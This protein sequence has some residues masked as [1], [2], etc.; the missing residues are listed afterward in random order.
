MIIIRKNWSASRHDYK[1]ITEVLRDTNTYIKIKK[2]PMRNIITSL[3]NLLIRWKDSK[4]ISMSIYKQLLSSDGIV[5]RAYGLPKIYKQSC[6]FRIIILLIES[7]LYPL[8]LFLHRII[9]KAIS[10][11]SRH[12]NNS[13][14]LVKK[15][16]NLYIDDNYVLISLDAISFFTNIL[17]DQAIECISNHWQ[18]FLISA[19]FLKMNSFKL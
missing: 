3:R 5:P 1:K 6:P 2:Y 16:S 19:M 4:Y 13:F 9:S 18:F 17:F 12:I 10:K 7:L 15:L 14:Q 8:A 11:S